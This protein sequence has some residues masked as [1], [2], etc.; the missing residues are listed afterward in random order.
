MLQIKL[1][2][3]LTVD[4]KSIADIFNNIFKTRAKRWFI[5]DL[6][7][8]NSIAHKYDANQYVTMFM[9]LVNKQNQTINT[10]QKTGAMY[11]TESA[12][13]RDFTILLP[14]KSIHYC[15]MFENDK[16]LYDAVTQFVEKTKHFNSSLNN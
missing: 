10:L 11:I 8:N 13:Q 3:D 4:F 1:T 6:Y 9:G 15:N 12:N 5:K 2:T 16:L 7:E 14:V